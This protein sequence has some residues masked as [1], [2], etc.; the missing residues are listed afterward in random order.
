MLEINL[1]E[2]VAE[3]TPY[4][5]E[6]QKAVDSNDF[7]TM[8]KL[9]WNSPQ[10]VRFGPV[11]TLIGYDKITAYRRERV[12]HVSSEHVLRNTVITTF[13]REFAATNTERI[14]PG[15]TKVGRQSQC[16]VRTPDGWRIASAHVSDQ[17]GT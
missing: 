17:P 14:K 11:G 8:N 1:P 16:W 13:G 15:S 5:L 12:G 4:Y 3:F 6:Y 2:V 10:T 9:F 7:E